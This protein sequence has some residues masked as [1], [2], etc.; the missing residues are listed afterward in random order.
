LH[1]HFTQTESFAILSG[2]VGTTSSPTSGAIG[3][4]KDQV[5]DRESTLRHPHDIEPWTPHTFWPVPD[6][7]EDSVLLL[8]ATPEGP[9]PPMMD[10]AFFM[11]ILRYFSDIA[12]KKATMDIP[13]IMINQ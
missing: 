6:A 5:H 9:F 7:T 2:Q 8:W 3:A 1:I 4:V 10:N 12:E 11:T 13:Q